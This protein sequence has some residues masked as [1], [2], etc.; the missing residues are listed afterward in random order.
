MAETIED[1]NGREIAV[2]RSKGGVVAVCDFSDNLIRCEGLPWP[3]PPVVQK[4]YESRQS[5]AFAGDEL[6]AVTRRLGFYSDLQS[7]NSEDAITW[8]YF[9]CFLAE[10]AASRAELMNRLLAYVELGDHAASKQSSIDLWRR[11]P[12]PD[13]PSASGGPELDVVVD[14][15]RAVIFLE[16]KWHSK[17]AKNQGVERTKSQLQLRRDFLGRIGPRVYGQ[18]AFLVVGIVLDEP[19]EQATPPDGYGV[20]TASIRWDELSSPIRLT[21]G[22]PRGDLHYGTTDRRTADH[23]L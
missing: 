1:W 17:E 15:E 12:H 6:A 13:R 18:R 16:A 11:I 23:R 4:L 8:S 10:P 7:I 5:R 2:V 9:G 21:R 3:P 14:G 20:Y 19:L 22:R